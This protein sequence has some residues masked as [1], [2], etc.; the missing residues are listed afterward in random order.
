MYRTQRIQMELCRTKM[1]NVIT[2]GQERTDRI[3]QDQEG[4]RD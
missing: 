4:S 1:S 3:K 2:E